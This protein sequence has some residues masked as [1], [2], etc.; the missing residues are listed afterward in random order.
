MTT[1]ARAASPRLADRSGPPDR[2]IGGSR[3]AEP[4]RIG[5]KGA[6]APLR[7]QG[8]SLAFL[9][10]AAS[11]SRP[12]ITSPSPPAETCTVSPSFTTPSRISPASAFCRLRWITRLSGRAP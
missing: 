11:A 10:Y 3:R 5:V 6:T 12:L 7:V 8:G 2:P 4:P 9:P 1:P